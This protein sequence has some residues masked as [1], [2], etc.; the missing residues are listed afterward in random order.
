MTRDQGFLP[1]G[2]VLSS[3]PAHSAQ[4]HLAGRRLRRGDYRNPRY[5]A[6]APGEV[7]SLLHRH[8]IHPATA[9]CR[10]SA[11]QIARRLPIRA[12]HYRPL[13]RQG[14][15]IRPPCPRCGPPLDR[16]VHPGSGAGAGWFPQGRRLKFLYLGFRCFR[17]TAVPACP[18]TGNAEH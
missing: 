11:F 1:Q 9:Y 17:R 15:A 18:R 10:R 6:A 7:C 13:L 8:R 5:V 16:R 2:G 14:R 3:P 12:R 4:G